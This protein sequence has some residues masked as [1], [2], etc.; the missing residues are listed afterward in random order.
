MKQL[1]IMMFFCFSYLIGQTITVKLPFYEAFDYPVGKRLT[2]KG[3]FANTVVDGGGAWVYASEV[4]SQDPKIVAQPWLNSKG[5]PSCKGNALNFKSGQDDP[6]ILFTT[7]GE[8]SGLIYASFLFKINSWSTCNP[9]DFYQT[10]VNKNIEEYFLSFANS[11]NQDWVLSK[12]DYF[13]RVYIKRD[14]TD[15]GFFIGISESNNLSKIAYHSQRYELNNDILVVIKYEYNKQEGTSYIWID[16]IVG[17]V[18]PKSTANT[19][20]DQITNKSLKGSSP[21]RRLVNRLII[22]KSSNEKTPNITLDEIRIAN[23]WYEVVGKPAI[24]T[25]TAIKKNKTKK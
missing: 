7:Q 12:N 14:N 24:V 11:E 13:S 18:E 3:T 21:V 22:N 1:T 2:P 6:S 9:N 8:E 20:T 16:P 23:T 4:I 10:W 5:L 15:N 25:T 19:L 17:S